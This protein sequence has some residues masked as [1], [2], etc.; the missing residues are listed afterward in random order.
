MVQHN[1][2]RKVD[3]PWVPNQKWKCLG[4]GATEDVHDVDY[5]R[6][7]ET[8]PN[9]ARLCLDCMKT[10]KV[11]FDRGDVNEGRL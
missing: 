9:R 11:V 1:G 7:A 3:I 2:T 5:L 6:G 4:C 8:I 10:V